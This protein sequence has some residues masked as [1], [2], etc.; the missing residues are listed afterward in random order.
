MVSFVK[1]VCHVGDSYMEN[2]LARRMSSFLAPTDCPPG[3]FF[4]LTLVFH[5][6]HRPSKTLS[7]GTVGPLK[8]VL[9]FSLP[10]TTVGAKDMQ[11]IPLNLREG[12]R[13]HTATHILLLIGSSAMFL[14]LYILMLECA[15]KI[16]FNQQAENRHTFSGQVIILAAMPCCFCILLR[17]KKS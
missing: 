14:L 1:C 4:F 12:K 2:W 10:T 5:H 8:E 13:T 16:S 3:S 11:A 15:V 6:P 9:L 17:I 7:L